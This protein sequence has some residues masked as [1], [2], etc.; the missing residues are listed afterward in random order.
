MR[1]PLLC[2]VALAFAS[3]ALAAPPVVCGPDEP[4]VAVLSAAARDN[5]VS[6]LVT[7]ED[8]SGAVRE[9]VLPAIVG[10]ART[11]TLAD[12]QGFAVRLRATSGE[13]GTTLWVAI[14]TWCQGVQIEERAREVPLARPV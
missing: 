6:L 4:K 9:V 11:V 12:Y 3:P 14:E 7:F 5:G 1:N 8:S 2:V 10:A 13:S